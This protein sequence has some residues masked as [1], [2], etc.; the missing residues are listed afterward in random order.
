MKIT[1]ECLTVNK[2]FF[3]IVVTAIGLFLLSPVIVF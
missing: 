1:L 2:R 3:D